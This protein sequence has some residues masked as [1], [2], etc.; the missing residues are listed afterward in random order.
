V[1]PEPP[2]RSHKGGIHPGEMMTSRGKTPQG[3][4]R[5]KTGPSTSYMVAL[6]SQHA[7]A[8]S[9]WTTEKST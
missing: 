8:S 4:S 2:G 7:G 5:K 1:V 6:A 3:T 9:S